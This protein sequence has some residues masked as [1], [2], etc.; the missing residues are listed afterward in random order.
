MPTSSAWLGQMFSDGPGQ[1]PG[2][3]RA[4]PEPKLRLHHFQFGHGPGP[5]KSAPCP[6]GHTGLAHVALVH[7]LHGGVMARSANAR[8]SKV[9]SWAPPCLRGR[10]GP[11]IAG[12][13]LLLHGVGH[14]A[15]NHISES[16]PSATTLGKNGCTIMSWRWSNEVQRTSM[17]SGWAGARC[18]AFGVGSPGTCPWRRQTVGLITKS[19]DGTLARPVQDRPLVNDAG[20]TG[21]PVSQVEEVVLVQIPV[22]ARAGLTRV[23][24]F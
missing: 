11:G 17:G 9:M 6:R 7:D 23:V 24:T 12:L 13:G 18:H 10:L 5:F 8:S 2:R 19:S 1:H 22:Q 15:P 14:G 21:M 3:I 16:S 20:T 4:H